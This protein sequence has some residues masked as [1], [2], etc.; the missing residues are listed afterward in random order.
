MVDR[1]RSSEVSWREVDRKPAAG[2]S[3]SISSDYNGL[4]RHFRVVPPPQTAE[5]PRPAAHEQRRVGLSLL[6]EKQYWTPAALARNCRFFCRAPLPSDIRRA[7]G[8]TVRKRP[9]PQMRLRIEPP[10]TPQTDEVT[11]DARSEARKTTTLATS[12]GCPRRF[13]GSWRSDISCST[14]SFGGILWNADIVSAKP[15]GLD[16]K[17]VQIGPGATAF[18]RMLGPSERASPFVKASTAAFDTE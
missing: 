8:R 17:G 1:A 11:N 13:N 5:R 7:R 4:R 10:S 12:S 16:Q 6:S 18:T 15:P 14:A 9:P 2:H 3:E